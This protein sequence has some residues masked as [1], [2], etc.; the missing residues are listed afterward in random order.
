MPCRKGKNSM[1]GLCATFTKLCNL[2]MLNKEYDSTLL[3]DR[4]NIILYSPV[5]A[6]KGRELSLPL[7]CVLSH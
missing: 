7:G 5:N 6:L 4:I 2:K 3:E 1:S